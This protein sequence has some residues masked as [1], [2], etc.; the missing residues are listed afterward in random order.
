MV[1]CKTPINPFFD[2]QMSSF[3]ETFLQNRLGW[4]TSF[5]TGLC[6][7]NQGDHLPWMPY[8][9]IEHLEENL[10]KDEVIFEYGL[11]TSSIFFANR[12]AKVICAESNAKW[13][14]VMM[15]LVGSSGV[16]NI[17]TILMSDALVNNKYE[18]LA[19][20]FVNNNSNF[21]GFDW[22]IVD[23]L[24]RAKC[25][26]NSL[27]ALKKGGKVLLDDSQRSSYKKIYNFMIEKGFKC[28]E[29]EG[30]SPGQLKSKKSWIFSR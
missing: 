16:S 8:L 15:E 6:Q 23:S 12:A 19:S 4:L 5:K 1:F 2:N 27:G 24:K 9:L 14:E 3:K 29:F 30:I 7:D 18:N 17:E 25:V 26:K 13:H 28:Q 22:I 11:G 10:K 20:D 21:P